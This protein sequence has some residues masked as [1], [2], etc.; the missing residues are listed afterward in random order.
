MEGSEVRLQSTRAVVCYLY[1]V[2]IESLSKLCVSVQNEIAGHVV[3]TRGKRNDTFLVRKKP[4]GEA[5]L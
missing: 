3:L 5:T 4:E 1:S 2:P